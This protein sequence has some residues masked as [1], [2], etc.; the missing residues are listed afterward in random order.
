MVLPRTSPIITLN[1]PFH[2]RIGSVGQPVPGVEVMIM[3]PDKDGLGELAVKGPNVM[4]GYFKMK[5]GQK[6]LSRTNISKQATWPR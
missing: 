5:P 1:T 2:H 3:E 4:P 6:R